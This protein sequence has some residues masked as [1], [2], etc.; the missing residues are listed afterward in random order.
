MT[1]DPRQGMVGPRRVCWSR[2]NVVNAL[3][4]EVLLFVR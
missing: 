4:L 1:F 3:L 2:H